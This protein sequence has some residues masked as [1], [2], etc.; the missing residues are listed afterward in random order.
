MKRILF[1]Y[2]IFV[3]L[4]VPELARAS[5]SLAPHVNGQMILRRYL[6]MHPSSDWDYDWTTA[7]FLY[8]SIRYCE[9]FA[10][11]NS[12]CA[13]VDA[14]FSKLKSKTFPQV[15][16]PDLAAMA[17]PASQW[18]PYASTEARANIEL[19]LANTKSFFAT[20]PL[21]R[22]DVFDHVGKRHSFYWWLPPTSWF[23]PSSVWADSAIMYGLNGI[24][25]AKVENDKKLEQ[26]SLEQL[27]KIQTVLLD[28]SVGLYKHAYFIPFDLY[29][30]RDSFWARGNGWMAFAMIDVISRVPSDNLVASKLK[31]ALSSLLEK[32]HPFFDPENGF[33]T[34]LGSHS[35]SNYFESSSS[36][37]Y[38]YALLKAVRAGVAPKEALPIA[39]AYRDV[40]IKKYLVPEAGDELSVTGISGPTTAIPFDWYY[41]YLIPTKTDVSYGVGAFLLLLSEP[42]VKQ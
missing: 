41:T 27:L 17:L 12:T 24:L 38:V 33:R 16:M 28:S 26:F 9:R 20:E 2:L 30:P 34:L 10:A 39:M 8:G 5:G 36:A 15:T 1:V 29:A 11:T 37:L 18:L 13:F 19:I 3:M 32:L 23:M 22:S 40:L 31:V 25:L 21:N 14:Y 6:R 4:G 42:D 7:I 35:K